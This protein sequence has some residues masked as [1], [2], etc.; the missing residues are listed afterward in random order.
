MGRLG[1]KIEAAKGKIKDKAQLYQARNDF[2]A[3]LV[4]EELE[5]KLK[6]SEAVT[7][8]YSDVIDVVK[9]EEKKHDKFGEVLKSFTDRLTK[10]GH[11]DA[12]TV[13]AKRNGDL[14]EIFQKLLLEEHEKHPK[15]K[16]HLFGR[17]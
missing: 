7:Q 14:S 13:M 8:L 15:E 11:H 3:L 5:K 6:H 10:E 1:Q 16:N 17:K 4:E 9:H 12:V 2:E